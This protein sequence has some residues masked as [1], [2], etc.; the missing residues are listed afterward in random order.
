MIC[1]YISDE[2]IKLIDGEQRGKKTVVKNCYDISTKAGSLESG[3]IKDTVV[4]TQALQDCLQTTNIKPTKTIYMLDNNRI[5]F[6][7]MIVP[8]VPDAKIK[9]V[10]VS[11]LFS[12]NKSANNTIDYIV[13][14]KFKDEKVS[15]LRIMVTY[16]NNEIIDN[17][18]VSA[19]ELGL[20]PVC[21]DIAPNTM[22]KLIGQ[23][24]DSAQDKKLLA[25][26]FLLLDFKDTFISIYVFKDYVMQFTKSTVL[27]VSDPDHPDLDYLAS[28]LSTQLVSTVRFYSSRNEGN[29]I[30]K[31]F[32]TGNALVLDKI[33]QELADAV[34]MEVSHL[35]LPSFVKGV[36]LIDYN[37]FSCAL[38]A[39]IR[40]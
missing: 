32:V 12:D 3:A 16:I 1:I 14:E 21:L 22:A 29:K 33:M 37:A 8:D 34:N 2:K 39:F 36:E 23:Y 6:R 11:E 24:G 17:L 13:L 27:Y 18:S 5:V 26:S 38:G 40:R 9:K 35:P 25:G 15:K 4:F 19:T 20:T 7:E 28:E 30:E 10:I 31:V